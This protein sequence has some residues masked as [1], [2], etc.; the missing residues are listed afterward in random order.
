MLRI[1]PFFLSILFLS[2]TTKVT[3]EDLTNLDGY[4]EIKSVTFKNGNT[5]EYNISTTVDY[6][7][8]EGLKGYRK[9]VQPKFNGTYDTSNDA[10]IFTLSKTVTSFIFNY[11]TNLSSWKEE[12]L[13]L[14][15]NEFSVKNEQEK[16]YTYQRYTPLNITK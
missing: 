3:E 11:K 9:K 8:V 7:K 16:I 2:C 14:S 4:W 12:L 15:K 10:E 1:L 5:K 6:I 13:T